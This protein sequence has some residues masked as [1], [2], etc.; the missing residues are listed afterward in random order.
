MAT[1][2]GP[3]LLSEALEIMHGGRGRSR[4][5]SRSSSTRSSPAAAA[6]AASPSPPPSL[7]YIVL[8]V[9]KTTP[10]RAWIHNVYASAAQAL[11]EQPFDTPDRGYA[12]HAKLV[13]TGAPLD[14]DDGM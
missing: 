13:N 9:D 8:A 14:D 7:V 2:D 10:G 11:Q 3:L 6:A 5:R 1:R 4:S 12:V